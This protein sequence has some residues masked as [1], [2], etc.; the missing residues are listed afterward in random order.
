MKN[1]IVGVFESEAQAVE[2]IESLKRNGIHTDHISVIAKDGD[3]SASVEGQTGAEHVEHPK[4]GAVL[5]GV[6]GGGAGLFA[7]VSTLAI[8]GIGPLLVGG[9]LAATVAGA[10]IGSA[11]GGSAGNLT[12]LG[13]REDEAKHYDA[14]LRA[15]RILVIAEAA[16][17]QEARAVKALTDAKAVN[18]EAL[19]AA[20]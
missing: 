3:V 7:S 1:H 18:A 12:E 19:Q 6:I 14:D 8:P 2:G 4:S 9:A 5:G 16:D 13:I 20:L 10:F 15:G 11:A 17:N